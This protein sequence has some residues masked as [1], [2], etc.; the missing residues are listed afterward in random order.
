M[1]LWSLHPRY[2]DAKGLVA[3]WREALLAQKVL[4][5]DSKGYRSHPQLIRFRRQ[6]DP[7]A[8]IAA[9]LRDVRQE[10]ERRGYRFD[11]GKIA[12][13]SGTA[14]IPVTDGQL[15]Y[16]LDQLK[17]RLRLRDPNA[18][19]RI[20]SLSEAE[21]HPLFRIISGDVEEWEMAGRQHRSG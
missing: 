9:Y 6:A 20:E 4:S 18:Y 7:L 1:R 15:K 21:P 5:G 8:A 14:K 10:A 3:L 16:E 11:S 17:S 13:T 2:L 12:V 19:L